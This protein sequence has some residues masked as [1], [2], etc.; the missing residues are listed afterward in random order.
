MRQGRL[1][2]R[3][4]WN[5][6]VCLVNSKQRQ[7]PTLS[8]ETM[9]VLLGAV[10]GQSACGAGDNDSGHSTCKARC[11]GLTPSRPSSTH[12]ATQ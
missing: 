11:R 2:N 8:A 3:I 12:F 6:A 7:L 10:S 1:K 4:G 5:F 9:N